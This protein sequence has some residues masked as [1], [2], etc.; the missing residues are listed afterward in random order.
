MR[1]L[2]FLKDRIY[3]L[4][5]NF[6][7]LI[8]TI[9]VIVFSPLDEIRFDTITYITIANLIFLSSY[10][11]ISY[12]KKIRFLKLLVN[13]VYHNDFQEASIFKMNNE[14][15]NYI[16]LFRTYHREAEDI[17]NKSNNKFQ[18]NKR[19]MDMWTHDIKMPISIIKLII[20][21]N[22]NPYFEQTLKEID[23]E[24]TR[25]ENSIE[26][27]LHLSRLDDFHND[28]LVQNVELDKVLKE[29]IRK[30]SK[31]FISKEIKLSLNNVDYVCLSDK[32]WLTFIL[33]QI[34]SNALK[35]T[36]VKD[37]ISIIGEEKDKSFNLIIKDTGCGIK[38]EDIN[39]IFEKGFTGTNGRNN[40]KSTGLGLYIA[41]ELC[42]KL[43]HGLK[44][45]STYNEF[46]EF[47]IIFKKKF[48]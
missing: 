27:L 6:S 36:D 45:D 18:E 48:H 32:K 24:I 33:D 10:L 14:E 12:I 34:I 47:I 4:I 30:Y 19:I 42:N 17:I 40:T 41:K 2:D 39:R 20:D 44:V 22:D 35:Y 8:F 7:F 13:R 25:I 21:G 1:F 37:S 31:W 38:R 43:D 28:F 11:V 5:F 26:I 16:E 3:F 46:T 9:F 15:K 23:N 29:I